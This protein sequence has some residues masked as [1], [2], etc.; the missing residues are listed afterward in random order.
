MVRNGLELESPSTS[1]E[2]TGTSWPTRIRAGSLSRVMIDGVDSRL[3][4]VSLLTALMTGPN[5][6]LPALPPMPARPPVRPRSDCRAARPAPCPRSESSYM[7][8]PA[9]TPLGRDAGRDRV[10]QSGEDTG[11]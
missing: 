9:P 8:R 3:E 1:P 10:G 7:S 2:V 11:V 5:N 4:P 6:V